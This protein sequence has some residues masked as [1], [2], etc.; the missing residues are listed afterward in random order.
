V[1][2]LSKRYGSG[3]VDAKLT[4]GKGGVFEITVD[5]DL[6]YSKKSTGQFPRYG[7]IPLAIDT[8]LVNK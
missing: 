6:V 8:M 1:A 7:E 2:E 3:E 4:A 5:G